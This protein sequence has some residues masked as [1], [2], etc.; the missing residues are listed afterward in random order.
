MVRTACLVQCR[1]RH[2][3]GSLFQGL[4]VLLL[5][6]RQPF[7]N[8]PSRCREVCLM[9]SQQMCWTVRFGLARGEFGV[10]MLRNFFVEW[11]RDVYFRT[12]A[13]SQRQVLI[14]EDREEGTCVCMF[15]CFLFVVA[16]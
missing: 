16:G 15:V 9:L 6:P 8:V 10:A 7:F 1:S 12:Y 11:V 14:A 4:C 13:S 3:L 2:R 5:S